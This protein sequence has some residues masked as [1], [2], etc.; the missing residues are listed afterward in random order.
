MADENEQ[1]ELEFPD[2]DDFPSYDDVES[3]EGEGELPADSFD[4]AAANDDEEGC[5]CVK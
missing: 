2:P 1:L 4:E 3:E 5:E